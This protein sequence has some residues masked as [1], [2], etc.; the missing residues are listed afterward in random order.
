MLAALVFGFAAVGCAQSPRLAN[1]SFETLPFLSAWSGTGVVTTPGL[2]G[3]AT[4]AR[5]PYNTLAA[6]S[7]SLP[8]PEPSFTFDV[9]LS[10]AGNTTTQGFTTALHSPSGPAIAVRTA[11]GG[12]LQ[13]LSGT[14][15]SPLTRRTDGAAFSLAP[16]QT[17]RLRII[18]R[19]FDNASAAFD[20]VWS[21]PGQSALTHAAT[22]LRAFPDHAPSVAGGIVSVHF[23]RAATADNSFTVDDVSVL[24]AAL[25]APAADYELFTTPPPPAIGPDK[26]VN[27]SGVYPH[28]AMTNTHDECGVGAVVPWAGKLWTLTYAPHTPYGSTD[29]LYE[30]APDLTRVIRPESI[31]GTPA[32]RFIHTASQQ[33]VIGPY[34]IDAARQVRALSYSSAPGRYTATAAHLTDPANRLYMF[35]MENALYDVNVHDLSFVTRYP[36]VQSTGDAFLAGYHG[37]GAY[38]S[39]GLLAVGNNG[40]PNQSLPSGV[41][42][43]WD[44]S[45]LGTGS[46]PDR[47]SAWSQVERIQTCEITGPGGIT[48]N[49]NPATDPLWT[50]GFDDKSVILH[51][52]ESGAWHTW[53]LP[54]ASYT[55]DGAHGWHTEWPRIRQLDPSDP[56]SPYL[57]HMHG[58]FYDFPKTFSASNFAGL[59]PL[60]S[61]YKMP[62]DYCLFEGRLVM[63]KN[64]TSRF[65]NALVPKAGSNL[66]FGQ[67]SDFAKWGA[68][69]GHGAVWKNDSVSAGQLSAPFLVSGFHQG[70]LHLRNLGTA[71]VS[72]ELQTSPGSPVWSV[73]R[74]ISVPDGGYVALN[75]N[76][77]GVPWLRLRALSASASLT[78]FFHLHSPYPHR[79]PASLGTDDFAALADIGDTSRYSDGLIRVT[80]SADMKLE[81]ASARADAS[82]TFAAHRYHV[83]GG[84]LQLNDVTDPAAAATLRT[85]AATTLQFGFDDASAWVTEGANRF[86]LPKL[87][88]R[89]ESAFPSGWARAFREVV[90][91]RQL[92][93]CHGT[94]YEVPRS[95]SGGLRKMRALTTHGKRIT[96]LASWRGLWVLTGVR[97]DAPASD[98]L[99]KNPD[100][101]AALWLGEIDDLWRLGEPRGTG[102][103][104]SSTPVAANTASDPYLMYGYDRKSVALSHTSSSPVTFSVEVDFL[105]D[106]S[107]STYVSLEVPAGETFTHVFPSG[108]HAHWVRLKTS[109]AT[110]ATTRFT[111][112]PVE[113]RD[114]FLDW[115][116]SVALPVGL[117]RAAVCT[118]DPDADGLSNLA[119]YFLG[120]A[121][122]DPASAPRTTA[123]A[124]QLDGETFLLLT[125]P[126]NPAATDAFAL[127]QT[128]LSLD[129]GSW[130]DRPDVVLQSSPASPSDS[131]ETVSAVLPLSGADRLFARLQ[132]F[133]SSP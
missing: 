110:T 18:G 108:F 122:L 49:P 129:P 86:R 30:I 76:D 43:T 116:R 62:V 120:G 130:V 52:L 78:A 94:F 101:T 15:W 50:T 37:K 74:S 10:L 66:W 124:F 29:K 128:S 9:S 55:H 1:G 102:G 27:I 77:L 112:G 115:A 64:D 12:V 104:W 111:Y 93:N 14:T 84:D 118:A 28:L 54:K 71:P 70:T 48:G 98:R 107:W 31:G 57:M 22:G 59:R 44:G 53:R 82:G 106:N 2:N 35:T 126:R 36:E 90:T 6:L 13:V 119:E 16:N 79:T 92:L 11:V 46:T 85:V 125:F 83:G 72:L 132:I 41:L 39:Q 33:L 17:L 47:M 100:G 51:T 96:D 5:L 97:D 38:T 99:L 73:L 56:A 87:D 123:S 109:S 60:A 65:S 58:L 19:D 113:A 45:V 32:N 40:E 133:T 121:P 105:G 7:Q 3:S 26:V 95:I 81:F 80:A 67:L 103:P 127:V 69:T 117:P 61:Y 89:Y 34:F 63:G 23:N 8:A 91:E 20:I 75:I 25:S 42:A 88:P 68:P 4:A 24:D 21:D 114:A 131:F